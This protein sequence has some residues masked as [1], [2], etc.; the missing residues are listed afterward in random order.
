MNSRL[1]S[2]WVWQKRKDKSKQIYFV[3]EKRNF[4][5]CTNWQV[6]SI[7]V[8]I[9]YKIPGGFQENYRSTQKTA[10]FPGVFQGPGK[11]RIK[12]WERLRCRWTQAKF[13]SKK[14][15]IHYQTNK[16]VIAY[17]LFNRFRNVM[18][19]VILLFQI[20]QFK[21]ANFGFRHIVCSWN[22]LSIPSKNMADADMRS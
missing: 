4:C 20:Q 9:L 12:G 5:E 11:N 22:A 6:W 10:V 1:D 2:I 8:Q 13:Y 3:Y 15:F 17:L 7:Q 21:W 19:I 16:K 18:K 14:S